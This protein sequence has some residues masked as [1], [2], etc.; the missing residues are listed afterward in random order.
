[1]DNH[2]GVE[3]LQE[4][5]VGFVYRI[6]LRGMTYIGKKRVITVTKK[7]KRVANNAWKTYTG[8]SKPLNADI[9]RFKT[10]PTFEILQWCSCL[11]ELNYVEVMWHIHQDSIRDPKCY[12]VQVGDTK[13]FH[14]KG[15]YMDL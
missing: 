2:W 14:A 3:E 15:W 4:G 13:I 11:S 6:K 12:N 1:M 7:R 10:K 5:A 9:D 8:S